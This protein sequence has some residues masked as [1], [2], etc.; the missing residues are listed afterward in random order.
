MNASWPV[1]LLAAQQILVLQRDPDGSFSL[2]GDPP[3]WACPVLP[4][5]GHIRP[6]E[7]F[8][9]L[10]VF[11]PQAEAL[12]RTAGGGPLR[13]GLWTET[14][15]GGATVQLVASAVDLPEGHFLLIR[16]LDVEFDEKRRFLQKAREQALADER[17]AREMAEK[18]I[19]LH[20]IVHDLSNPLAAMQGAFDLMEMTDLPPGLHRYA[21]MGRSAAQKQVVLIQ[22]LLDV[23]AADAKS[24]RAFDPS[25]TPGPDLTDCIEEVLRGQR[26][27]FETRGIV[28][29]M[30]ASP[31][32]PAGCRVVA[33][34][35]RLE[36]VLLN[37][38]QNALRFAPARSSIVVEVRPEGEWMEVA[39]VDQ[40]AGVPPELA[41]QLFQ[42]FI[43]GASGAGKAGLGLFFC[44][45]TVERWGGSIGYAP[46]PGGG[47][48]FWFRLRK[49]DGP[50]A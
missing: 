47:A 1:A 32:S 37:L 42:R 18:E 11:L 12:W 48:R 30:A 43:K 14:V 6:D 31:D 33:E 28:V 36:R 44:R 26:P 5:D 27:T 19:L 20:C 40:G 17:L 41:P 22:D 24:A 25:R 10:S 29:R 8:P 16:K 45:I 4:A 21:E 2:Q 49:M 35:D 13:S 50:A 38:L 7:L 23:F 39:V 3:A 15:P 46:R 34:R 9:F